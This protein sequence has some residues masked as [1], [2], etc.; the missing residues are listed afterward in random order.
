MDMNRLK[1]QIGFLVEIDKLKSI[2]R[3]AVLVDRSRHE[4]DAEH[5]WHLAMM[6]LILHEHANDPG[7]DLLRVVKMVLI[8][9]IV[10][11]DAGDVSA[12]DLAGQQDKQ[13]QELKAA[14]RLFGML[15]EEQKTEMFE[16]WQEFEERSTPSSQFAAALDRLAPLLHNYHTEGAT[17]KEHGITLDMVMTRNA[18]IGQGSEA[19]WQFAQELIR[20]AVEKEYLPLD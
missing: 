19:L 14:H 20:D 5:S 15:P 3:R 16:L 2:Y 18:Q 8:H 13:V 11:I 12:Y 6:A 4:N 10:E 17:W 1:Q 9:D 7:V